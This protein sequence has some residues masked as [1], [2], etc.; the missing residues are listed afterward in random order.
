VLEFVFEKRIYFDLE[1]ARQAANNSQR[2]N[3]AI[4]WMKEIGPTLGTLVTQCSEIV[5]TIVAA[6]ADGN[7]V[8]YV[9]P[10]WSLRVGIYFSCA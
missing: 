3:A 2:I 8:T 9:Q 5:V 10:H 4:I 6:C 1:V 7:R